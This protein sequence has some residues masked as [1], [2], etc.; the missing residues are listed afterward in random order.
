[1]I[2]Y[3]F[4]DDWQA[5]G[6]KRVCKICGYRSQG[7]GVNPKESWARRMIDYKQVADSKDPEATTC[8]TA[9]GKIAMVQE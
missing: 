3:H 5:Y 6:T 1:M 9:L 4:Q 7:I 2:I 8:N